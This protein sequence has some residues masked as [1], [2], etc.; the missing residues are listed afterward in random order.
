LDGGGHFNLMAVRNK[1]I[2]ENLRS[3]QT[4]Y[5]YYMFWMPGDH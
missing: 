5:F 2:D 3:V 1:N 4:K